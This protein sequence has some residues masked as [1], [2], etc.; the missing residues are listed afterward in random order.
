MAS[1]TKIDYS[2]ESFKDLKAMPY[3]M[4]WPV[5]YMLENQTELYVGETH[6]AHRRFKEHFENPER[7]TLSR[8]YLIGDPE[9]NKSAT[10]DT[11]SL[12]IQ[13]LAADSKYK[14][15]NGNSGL[16]NYNYFEKEKY[17]AKFER[18][19]EQLQELGIA[20]HDL[21]QLRNSDL[22]KYS[23]YKALSDEQFRVVHDIVDR[24]RASTSD[25]FVVHGEP[26][27]GKTIVGVYLMK[28]LQEQ[29]ATK[30]LK[31]A[32]VVPVT[33]L[34]K[35]LK[36]VFA[37][38]EGLK[39]SMVVGPNEVVGHDYDLL[40]VDEAHRLKRR[41]NLTNYATHDISNKKLG[42]G[43]EG[44][45]LDWIMKSSK[46]Q[47]LLYDER[48]T[49]MPTDIRPSQIRDLCSVKYK[50]T[51]QMRVKGGED[52]LEFIDDFLSLKARY[53][54]E[55]KNYEFV[56]CDTIK[57]L[58]SAVD[59]RENEIGLSRVV[60]G[61]AWPWQTKNNS[62]I[63]YDIEIDDVK[64]RWNS[65]IIDWV[66]SKNARHEVGCIH[67]IQGYDLNYVGVII[68]PE[69]TYDAIT[70]TLVVDKNRYVD[71]N[72]KR[73][74]SDSAELEDYIRN[75]YKTLLTRG[76]YGTYVYAV[77]PGLRSYLKTLK[78]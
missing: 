56:I 75:I 34:R 52:Y 5:V 57:Q 12:L 30:D 11:E 39:R 49:V 10:L 8:A 69:L 2:R 74:I 58:Q 43:K 66:N 31:V 32:L 19:W 7:R 65:V 51:S 25:T 36:N 67:T 62:K 38:V 37:N 20:D 61:Y 71:F 42:L 6:N 14:L 1:I 29:P 72:G 53:S 44:T 48:Q 70:K 73:S 63:A 50:L 18:L 59:V 28:Y 60:A 41:V 9:Y 64:L 16:K 3:G 15:Q 24:I 23:P 77:D 21:L 17:R 78:A 40:V 55:S 54:F 13:Y 76:I 26:G 46:F 4:N 68:G 47:I 45:Q 33:A 22:F 27:T 35:T